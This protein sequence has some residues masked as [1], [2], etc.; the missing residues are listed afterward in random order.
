MWGTEKCVIEL[1][2]KIL[3]AE[4]SITFADVII[5]SNCSQELQ[6]KF[7]SSWGEFSGVIS[8]AYLKDTFLKSDEVELVPDKIYI[9]SLTQ[10]LMQQ[11]E[12]NE[13]QNLK[14]VRRIG[15]K[16]ALVWRARENLQVKCANCQT[17]GEKSIELVISDPLTSRRQAEWVKGTVVTQQSVLVAKG[18][19][20]VTNQGLTSEMFELQ[21][22]E[23]AFPE[24]YFINAA[25]LKFN[26]LNK[27]INQGTALQNADLVALNLVTVGNPVK[28]TLDTGTIR[29]ENIATPSRNGK[30]GETIKFKN[31]NSNKVILGK[32]VDFNKAQVTL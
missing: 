10:Y 25:E 12:L 15:R 23:T 11:L 29:V 17:L 2:D 4:Q 19:F 21:M 24:R 9:S 26:K 28:M 3:R 7:V 8:T 20:S 13:G 5:K 16:G 30:L 32:I 6:N 22:I 14:D 31:L 1:Y 18:H 27:P